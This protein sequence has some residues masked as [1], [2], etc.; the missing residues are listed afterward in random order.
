MQ[1]KLFICVVALI[2]WCS[3]GQATFAQYSGQM[4]SQP[5]C[6]Y[7][8]SGVAPASYNAP[9]MNLLQTSGLEPT[10]IPASL[11][12]GGDGGGC[13]GKC[14]GGC[15]DKGGSCGKCNSYD[16]CCLSGGYDGEM[17][18]YGDFLY[19]RARDAEVAYAVPFDGPIVAGLNTIQVAPVGVA[20]MDFQ[21]GLRAG[22]DYI[23]HEC[24]KVS[25]VY[26][27]FESGTRDQVQTTA[28]LVIRPIVGHPGTNTAGQTFVAANAQYDM[29]FDLVDFDVHRLLSYGPDHQLGYVVGLR[30]GQF[31]QTLQTNYAGNTTMQVETDIDFYGAGLRGGLEWERYIGCQW[32]FYAR[33]CG[34]LVPGE[35]RADFDQRQAFDPRVVDTGWKGGRL[36]TMWDLEMGVGWTSKG[37]N[38][39]LDAGYIFSAWTN[40]VQTDEWIRG[41]HNNSFI[42]MDDTMTFDGLVGRFTAKF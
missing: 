11:N 8:P 32:Q 12:L 39:S 30:F 13:D 16:R 26:T 10:V 15:S 25:A 21:P 40:V 18:F 37:G 22:F 14:G 35:F 38:F 5:G 7:A 3:A 4:H 24:A 42:D 33:G 31:E 41:V 27:M 28:P 23:I 9:Q 17:A 6:N 34:S 2:G 36:V 29:S 20:D 19:L 1:T